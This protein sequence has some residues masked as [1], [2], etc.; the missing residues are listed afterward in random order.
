MEMPLRA[1]YAGTVTPVAAAVG[2]QVELG[3]PLFTVTEED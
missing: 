2:D 3:Q 1:P